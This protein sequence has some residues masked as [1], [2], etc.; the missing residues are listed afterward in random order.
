MNT[1]RR[2]EIDWIRNISILMLFAYH[3]SAIFCQFGDFYIVSEQK[4]FLADLL[5]LLLFVWYMPMLFFLAGASTY[6]S[7]RKRNL[8]EYLKERVKKLLIPLLFGIAVLVPPQTYLARIWRGENDLNYFEHIKFFFTNITDFTGFDGALTPAHLWFVLYLLII[9]TI[10]GILIFSLIKKDTEKAFVS[11]LN[12][13]VSNKFSFIILLT[14][15]VGS[16]IF[17]SIMGKSILGCFIV[18]ILG[19]SVYQDEAVLKKISRNRFKY[20]FAFIS[21]ALIGVLYV[22]GIRPS[23]VNSLIWILDG[24]LKNGILISAICLVVGFSSLH[25]NKSNDLLNYLNKSAFS[26]YIIHQPILL[27]VAFFVIPLVKSTT[28][29]M[30]SIIL[31]SLVLTFLVYEVLSRIKIFNFLFSI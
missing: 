3:T 24:I 4:S 20:L 30:L 22:L 25:I 18:F 5:V 13:T 15:G 29:A 7:S 28:L 10:A 1:V 23:E 27:A 8:K 11:I 16:D 21:F 14:I 31:I 17:P 26:I 2:Y 6:F 9:S 12:N 19:Y